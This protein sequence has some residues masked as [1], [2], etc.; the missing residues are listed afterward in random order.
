MREG[1]V[2][3]M[4]NAVKGLGEIALR[5][6]DLERMQEFYT[7]TVGLEL[8]QRFPTI[9]FFRIAEGVAGHTQILA[10]FDRS[11]EPDYQAP[12][13]AQTTVD[14]LAF[15]IE[16]KDFAAEKARLEG[17]RVTVTTAEH[18]WVHWRSLYFADPEGNTVELVCYDESV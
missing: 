14:H 3:G 9:A 18:A 15:S 6:A 12:R 5:V 17:L 4:T 7:T 2:V 1:E 13:S 10:L 16:L 8:L 11:A